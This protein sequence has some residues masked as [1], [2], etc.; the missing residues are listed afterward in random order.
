MD[1]EVGLDDS[2]PCVWVRAHGKV[3]GEGVRA[4]TNAVVEH[5]RW[6]R[7]MSVLA[8]Y[9]GVEGYHLGPADVVDLARLM[10]PF[11]A[12]LGEGRLA[13]VLRPGL[14]YGMARVW[15]V[16]ASF[17]FLMDVGVFRGLE[18]AHLWIGQAAVRAPPPADPEL[19]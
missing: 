5:P 15:R 10:G 14:V 16:H 19:V 6:R 4:A 8:D 11:A 7:G 1:F 9:R 18:Q 17:Q 3:T 13:L 2:V 12:Q